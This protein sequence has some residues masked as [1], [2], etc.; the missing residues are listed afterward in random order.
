MAKGDYLTKK[1]Y[2]EVARGFSFLISMFLFPLVF[3]LKD[4]RKKKKYNFI[5]KRNIRQT[6]YSNQKFTPSQK[7]TNIKT[8]N[9]QL[10]K[11]FEI[12]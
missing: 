2:K 5:I 3:I 12:I 11:Y 7:V 4:K 10:E 1:D 9:L 8:P 6:S